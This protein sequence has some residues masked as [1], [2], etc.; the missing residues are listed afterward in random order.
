MRL[1]AKKGP[2]EPCPR[3]LGDAW[4]MIPIFDAEG[5]SMMKFCS[6]IKAMRLLTRWVGGGKNR[7]GEVDIEL[8][9]DGAVIGIERLKILGLEVAEL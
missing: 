9:R 7:F 8:M 4:E 1:G 3:I 6:R 2:D 5:Q